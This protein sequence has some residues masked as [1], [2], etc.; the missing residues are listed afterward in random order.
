MLYDLF[1]M[2]FALLCYLP[3]FLLWIWLCI[4]LI[5]SIRKNLRK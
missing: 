3:F 2:I 1:V 4:K 5:K